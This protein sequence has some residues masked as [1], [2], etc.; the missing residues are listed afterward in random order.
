[1]SVRFA[2][3]AKRAGRR[4]TAACELVVDLLLEEKHRLVSE[5]LEKTKQ[6]LAAEELGKAIMVVDKVFGSAEHAITLVVDFLH[7]IS[8]VNQSKYTWLS[9][10][11]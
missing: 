11:S 7:D 6:L 9:R 1:M 3:Y 8:T 4:H 2:K 10:S 5:A